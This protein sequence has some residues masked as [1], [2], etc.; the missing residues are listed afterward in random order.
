MTF[1][2][3]ICRYGST[4]LCSDTDGWRLERRDVRWN[5]SVRRCYVVRCSRLRLLR[6]PLHLRQLYPHL[7]LLHIHIT[8]LI[9]ILMVLPLFQPY[10]LPLLSDCNM[11]TASPYYTVCNN[12][13]N[14]NNKLICI[15]PVC[16]LTSEALNHDRII[17]QVIPHLHDRANIEQTSS[18]YEACIKHSLHEAASSKHRANIEQTSNKH[19]ANIEQLYYVS[20]TSQL[21][22]VNGV[23]LANWCSQKSKTLSP[24]M[25]IC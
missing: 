13:N 8:I 3:R 16:R 1:S 17:V 19:R 24:K 12:N 6:R 4:C 14:N 21:H 7:R 20:W 2:M 22:R 23:L 10:T 5:T 9:T 25:Q 15:A 18:K 11:W